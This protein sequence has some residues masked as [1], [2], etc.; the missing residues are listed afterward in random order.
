MMTRSGRRDD[1]APGYGAPAW[2]GGPAWRRAPVAPAAGA[3]GGPVAARPPRLR[4]VGGLPA[5][6][7][8]LLSQ[9]GGERGPEVLR[10]EDLADLEHG[11]GA[12]GVGAALGPLDGL[13]HRAHLPQPEAGDQL[14]GLGEGAVDHRPLVAGEAH[15]RSPGAGVE[16]FT[17]EHD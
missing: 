12:G 5:Q 14:L 9:L 10:L 15:P 17:G 7:L 1:T 16:S 6:T 3:A 11:L 13:L 8:L 4:P 2:R